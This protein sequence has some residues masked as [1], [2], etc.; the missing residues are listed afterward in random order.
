L[1]PPLPPKIIAVASQ[2]GGAGKTTL[3]TSLADTL[4]LDGESVLLID[5][6][7]Q[8]SALLWSE[9]PSAVQTISASSAALAPAWVARLASPY[10]WVIIDC[11]PRLGEST[12]AAVA[13]AD[14]VLV[15]I[16]PT[17]MDLA[18]LPAT[19]KALDGHPLTRGVITQ[20]PPRSTAADSAPD[21]VRAAGLQV[22]TSSIAFRQDFPD[23][24][25]LGMSA[26]RAAPKSKA[27][28]EIKALLKEVRTLLKGTP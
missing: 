4:A 13:V 14:L 25:S 8:R 3:A 7:P 1:S 15:P 20:R 26:L 12:L 11:P 27:A 22:L 23:A 2:K 9:T 17:A 21:A 6:D 16:R 5:L 10:Q 28:A 19:L 24:H 18:V